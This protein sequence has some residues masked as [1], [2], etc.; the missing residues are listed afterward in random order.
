MVSCPQD[1]TILSHSIQPDEPSAEQFVSHVLGAMLAP[2]MGEPR[3]PQAVEICSPALREALQP[4]AERIGVE[5]VIRDDLDHL[6]HIER[7]LGRE[8][9]ASSAIKPMIDVPGL[10][11]PQIAAFFSAAADFY[12]RAPWRA[13]PGDTPIAVACDRFQSG[14]WYAVVMGQSGMVQGIALYE[15]RDALMDMLDGDAEQTAATDTS[16]LAVTYGEAFEMPVEDLDAA[17]KHGWEI[18]GPEAYPCPIR[19]NPGGAVRPPL[20]WELALLE[21]CL[22]AVPRFLAAGGDPPTHRIHSVAGEMTLELAWLEP[23]GDD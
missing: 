22:R 18:A 5:C 15:D 13:V 19:V 8:M 17:E 4:R 11:R 16:S 23:K 12:R 21:A 9:N 1:D 20:A 14:P 6:D 2:M 3:R 10:D 7:V